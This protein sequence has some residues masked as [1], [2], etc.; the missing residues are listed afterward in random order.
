MIDKW[1]RTRTQ[2]VLYGLGGVAVMMM[3]V[4]WPSVSFLPYIS[5]IARLAAMGSS[6]ATWV[7][8]PELYPTGRTVR[9]LH[10]ILD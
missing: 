6:C 9:L 8:T 4:Q 5:M 2:A 7:V 1:G 3:A 10:D